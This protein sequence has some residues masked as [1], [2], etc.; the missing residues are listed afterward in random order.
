MFSKQFIQC[1]ILLNMSRMSR[2]VT[3]FFRRKVSETTFSNDEDIDFQV[4]SN[5]DQTNRHAIDQTCIPSSCIPGERQCQANWFQKFS[6][7]H[8][9]TRLVRLFGTE[10]ATGKCS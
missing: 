6:W 7:L 4:H 1:L 9:D 5:E 10:A 8:Y 2:K 3:D